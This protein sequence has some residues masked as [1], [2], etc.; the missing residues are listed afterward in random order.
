MTYSK[1]ERSFWE[2][3][4]ARELTPEEKYFW[5]YL[6]TNANVNTLGC[7]AFRM[8]KAVDETGYNKDTL[9]KLLDI[10][11][12][13][14]M[15]LYDAATREV[16]LLHWGKTNWNRQTATLRAI[17]ADLKEI[18]SEMIKFKI[19]TQLEK[20][21]IFTKESENDK[22]SGENDKAENAEISAKTAHKRDDSEQT[23]T[24]GNKRSGEGEGEG[25]GEK[26]KE[27]EKILKS[28]SE[29]FAA[30]WEAYPN[31]KNKAVAVKRWDSLRVTA[32]LYEKI[33]AGLAKAKH[34]MEWAERG[35]KY[36]PYP[37]TWLNAEGWENEYR[38]QRAERAE[39]VR[40]NAALAGR[41]SLVGS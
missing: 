7:Y 10:M 33:M 32:G 23:G 24:N 29:A 3:D 20:S 40:E 41:R 38:P 19:N 4:E 13:R 39:P 30:F 16:F 14:G 37:S 28:D 11:V 35:G 26:K 2:T 21:G 5:M 22:I 6:Q 9:E 1:I 12:Q 31:K 18:R 17:K 8:R 25:K 34:S 36:I 15:I 27:K